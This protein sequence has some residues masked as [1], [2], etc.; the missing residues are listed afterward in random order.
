VKVD[1]AHQLVA[2]KRQLFRDMLSLGCT[3]ISPS[4]H[5]ADAFNSLYG[6]GR[7]Q[8]I[9]NGIDVATEAI[10]AELTPVAKPRANRKSLSLRMTCVTTV[11]PTSSWCAT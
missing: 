4:Q 1:R 3:F 8:I 7:C 11:K 2:G 6:A 9:N 10:L 5:V